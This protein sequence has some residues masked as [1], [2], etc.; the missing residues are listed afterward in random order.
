MNQAIC[1]SSRK[2]IFGHGLNK[3]YKSVDKKRSG[4]VN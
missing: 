2:I 1:C 4:S 3:E